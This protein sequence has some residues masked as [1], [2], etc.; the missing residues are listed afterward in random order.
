MLAKKVYR[1]TRLTLRLLTL[2]LYYCYLAAVIPL[3]QASDTSAGLKPVE[4]LQYVLGDPPDSRALFT[5]MELAVPGPES[6]ITTFGL[7]VYPKRGA[8]FIA[9]DLEAQTLIWSTRDPL[10]I[11]HYSLIVTAEN[12]L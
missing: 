1:H 11:G 8:K 2:L 6:G 9:V 12:G 5:L 3:S 7:E 4:T 10:D